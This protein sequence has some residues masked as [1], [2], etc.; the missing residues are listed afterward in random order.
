MLVIWLPPNLYSLWFVGMILFDSK[1][2]RASWLLVAGLCRYSWTGCK[3][4]FCFAFQRWKSVYLHNGSK[5]ENDVGLLV[6]EDR[7]W[8]FT[9][10]CDNAFSKDSSLKAALSLAILPSETSF[11]HVRVER[12]QYLKWQH[13]DKH[14]GEREIKVLPLHFNLISFDACWW[15]Y[16]GRKHFISGTESLV[17]DSE[18][19]D[20]KCEVFFWLSTGTFALLMES[21]G[22]VGGFSMQRSM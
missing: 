9:I 20:L 4:F 11:A 5:R 6:G 8:I 18:L 16:C 14:I 15:S 21:S 17:G 7:C 13:D 22:L 3:V 12:S 10:A 1:L 19:E 2:K